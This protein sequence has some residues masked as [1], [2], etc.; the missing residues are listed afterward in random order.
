[1]FKEYELNLNSTVEALKEC[2]THESQDEND[3]MKNAKFMSAKSS[4]IELCYKKFG[5][6]LKVTKNPLAL[7]FS[8]LFTQTSK[9]MKTFF[10]TIS[11]NENKRI[12]QIES[13]SNEI[14]LLN[15]SH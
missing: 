9:L 14:Q 12:K 10:H 15:Y 1:M 5:Y 8:E 13:L 2:A 11:E 4:L 3:Y 6:F 7:S